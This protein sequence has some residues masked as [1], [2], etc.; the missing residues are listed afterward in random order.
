MAARSVE[1]DRQIACLLKRL[2][3]AQAIPNCLAV[4][5]KTP[6][7]RRDI[8]ADPSVTPYLETVP[9]GEAFPQLPSF[10]HPNPP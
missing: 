3:A 1:K 9:H 4:M 8:P 5:C 2:I 10:D 7:R 6:G